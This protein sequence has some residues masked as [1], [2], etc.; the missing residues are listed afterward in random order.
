MIHLKSISATILPTL[1]DPELEAT[2]ESAF[3]EACNLVTLQGQ[4]FALV[5]DKVGDGPLNAVVGRDQALALIDS[6]SRITGDGRCLHL[7]PGWRLDLEA[8]I[9]WDPVPDFNRLAAWP[10]VVRTNLAWLRETIP[11]EAPTASFAS[12]PQKQVQGAFGSRPAMTIVQAQ[13]ASLT[14]GLLD[15]YHH[16]KMSIVALFAQR[17]AGLGPGLTPA[18]DDWLAGWLVG[19]RAVGSMG[20]SDVPLAAEQVG[21]TVIKAARGRTSDFSLA[22]LEM[23]ATGAVSQPWHDLLEAL[24][25]ADPVPIRHAASEIMRRGA[26]SGSDMLAG[27]LAAFDE[28]DNDFFG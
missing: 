12:E 7:G 28:P 18:G 6:G 22:F 26:T 11:L 9:S 23:A 19:L 8:A 5:S 2:V 21:K 1:L 4:H 16:G 14:N 13:A 15:A 24:S 17:L 3:A 27:F 20:L 25:S 10:F